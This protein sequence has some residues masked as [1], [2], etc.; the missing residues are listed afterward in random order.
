MTQQEPASRRD[1]SRHHAIAAAWGL[2]G[3]LPTA[4]LAAQPVASAA[5]I[6][7]VTLRRFGGTY[8]AAC[9]DPAAV[10]LRVTA[11][12]LTVEQGGQ[13]MTGRKPTSDPR[14]P[15]DR[16][17]GQAGEVALS[18]EVRG[19]AQL[20]FIAQIDAAGPFL[21]LDGDPKVTAALGHA[22]TAATYRR[23]GPPAPTASTNGAPPLAALIAD[24]AFERA[25]LRALGPL[26]RQ[27]WLA[28][29]EGPAAPTRAQRFDGVAYVVIAVCKAHDCYDHSA[30]F[31]YS[32]AQQRVLGLVQQR[33]AKTV[34]GMPGPALAPRL[35][36]LWLKEWRQT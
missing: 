24:P 30:V 2:V 4:L 7:A 6:D 8:A 35:D 36:R 20:V 31:L 23:C 19:G 3:L 12:A 28:R 13:R 16:L 17:P 34:L 18:S 1:R 21:R 33:G 5:G 26:T 32:A 29:F 9:A 11:Q 10:R 15:G 22:L 27:R 25:Y 14:H